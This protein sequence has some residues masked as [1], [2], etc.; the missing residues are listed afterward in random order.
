M[1]K[2]Q[3]AYFAEITG[4]PCMPARQ[5]S[6]RQGTMTV[7]VEASTREGRRTVV[8]SSHATTVMEGTLLVPATDE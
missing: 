5:L 3:G 6:A 1:Y 2:R 4:A 7:S 8:L